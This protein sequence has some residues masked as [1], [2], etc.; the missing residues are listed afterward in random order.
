MPKFPIDAQKWRVVKTLELLGFRIVREK[1][2][3]EVLWSSPPCGE[4]KE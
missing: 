2:V 3:V 4:Q 1:D